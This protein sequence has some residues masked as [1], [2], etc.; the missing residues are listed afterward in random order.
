MRNKE[1]IINVFVFVSFQRVSM[2]SLKNDAWN[3]LDLDNHL[4]LLKEV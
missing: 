1:G 4:W 2:T 3:I